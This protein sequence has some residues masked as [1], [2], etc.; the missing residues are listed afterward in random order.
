MATVTAVA[1][2]AAFPTMGSRMIPTKDTFMP[3]ARVTSSMLSTRY[4]LQKA[5]ATVTATSSRMELVSV[6]CGESLSSSSSSSSSPSS[7]TSP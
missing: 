6:S 4:S 7:S 2:S 1:C 3:H 5:T